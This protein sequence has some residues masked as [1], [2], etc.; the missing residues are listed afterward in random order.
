MAAF[1]LFLSTSIAITFFLRRYADAHLPNQKIIATALQIFILET[2]AWLVWRCLLYPN[3]FSPLRTL[4]GPP[5]CLL[6]AWYFST[7]PS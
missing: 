4:P 2:V 5:V 6:H 7:S 3:F 1:K